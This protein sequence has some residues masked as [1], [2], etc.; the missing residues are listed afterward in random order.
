MG[1]KLQTYKINKQNIY[2]M[3]FSFTVC[4]KRI[5]VL[6]VYAI[7]IFTFCMC[8]FHFVFFIFYYLLSMF[9]YYLFF[10]DI[11]F[12]VSIYF[13]FWL[14]VRHTRCYFRVVFATLYFFIKVFVL[15]LTYCNFVLKFLKIMIFQVLY[16]N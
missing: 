15:F 12:S 11:F 3:Y 10:T 7:C 9:F 6:S 8:R 1:K 5:F 14:R 13:C 4:K 16:Y 2:I